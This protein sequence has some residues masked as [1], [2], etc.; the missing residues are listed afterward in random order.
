VEAW[1]FWTWPWG[2]R[3]ALDWTF[4]LSRDVPLEL[5]LETG[6]SESRIDLGE[7]KV[8]D[9]R[10]QTG[11]SSTEL[12]LPANAGNTRVHVGA[13]AASVVVRVPGGVAAQ[14][15]SQSGLASVRVDQTRFPR[16]GSYYQS[17]DYATAANKVDIYVEVG[18]GSVDIR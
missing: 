4:G 14:I 1:T 2:G 7:L 10:L 11:A 12:S 9:V 8:T 3:G 5:R 6:A 15:R 13:G 17:P 18:V 16:N